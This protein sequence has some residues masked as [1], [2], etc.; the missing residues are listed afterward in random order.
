MNSS[1]FENLRSQRIMPAVNI[2]WAVAKMWTFKAHQLKASALIPHSSKKIK[3]TQTQ[4][5]I[6]FVWLVIS[7]IHYASTVSSIGKSNSNISTKMSMYTTATTQSEKSLQGVGSTFSLKSECN[8]IQGATPEVNA[9]DI[10][11]SLTK[12]LVCI[13]QK[14]IAN[15]KQTNKQN[16]M[17]GLSVSISSQ[18]TS[19]EVILQIC[20]STQNYTITIYKK[21][22][23]LWERMLQN[24][25]YLLSQ[26]R[27]EYIKWN[28]FFRQKL[29][30]AACSTCRP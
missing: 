5:K 12:K 30:V 20:C 24:I 26:F 7:Y 14:G 17:H 1:R 9:F 23:E 18:I 27:L 11:A 21:T 15:G 19:F 25:T 13:R 6:L 8:M 3:L 2:D 10:W 4:T 28:W 22:N 29:K 16:W